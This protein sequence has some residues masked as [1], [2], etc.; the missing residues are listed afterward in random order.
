MFSTGWS[1]CPYTNGASDFQKHVSVTNWKSDWNP[2]DY[3]AA[4]EMTDSTKSL[5]REPLPQFHT[6]PRTREAL[7]VE[8]G[9]VWATKE[10][11][12]AFEITG[13]ALAV[14]RKWDGKKGTVEFQDSPRLYFNWTPASPVFHIAT[15]RSKEA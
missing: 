14:R 7:E 8:Y 4:H 15:P 5:C 1:V 3:G 12:E 11:T 13:L 6:E 9:E 2:F 10:F